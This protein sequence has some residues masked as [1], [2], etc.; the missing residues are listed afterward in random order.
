MCHCSIC[1][2]VYHWQ[3]LNRLLRV[4]PGT[5]ERSRP[6]SPRG[7]ISRARDC[8][9]WERW[10]APGRLWAGQARPGGGPRPRRGSLGR[11]RRSV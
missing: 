4:G 3:A 11:Q 8:R 10:A 9:R 1:T 7:A 2:L 6:A 5:Y